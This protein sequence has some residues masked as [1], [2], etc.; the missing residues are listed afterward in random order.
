LPFGR[1]GLGLRLEYPPTIRGSGSSRT[2]SIGVVERSGSALSV[3][4]GARCRIP[5]ANKHLASQ[6]REEHDRQPNDKI[7]CQLI[8]IPSAPLKTL[9]VSCCV[10][11]ANTMCHR[12]A[13][14]P[15]IEGRTMRAKPRRTRPARGYFLHSWVQKRLV[16]LQFRIDGFSP[17]N[18]DLHVLDHSLLGPESQIKAKHARSRHYDR[19]TGYRG[20]ERRDHQAGGSTK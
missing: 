4:L 15:P 6:T 13:L 1:I 17:P 20:A 12:P 18:F 10:G 3:L 2:R 14:K 11:P 8:V 16:H 7:D 9:V 19:T 5:S